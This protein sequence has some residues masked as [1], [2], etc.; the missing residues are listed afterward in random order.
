MSKQRVPKFPR[1]RYFDT[2]LIAT[3][4]KG[5]GE[6]HREFVVHY[7]AYTLFR[8]R[9]FSASLLELKEDL[10]L[11][12]PASTAVLKRAKQLLTLG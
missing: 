9:Y 1:H 3:L 12:D 10:D 5:E 4:D 7:A 8:L 2:A 11:T 6:M